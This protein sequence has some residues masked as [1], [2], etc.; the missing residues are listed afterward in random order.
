M[1]SGFMCG[2]DLPMLDNQ[3]IALVIA[4]IIEQESVA[5]IAG[6][7]IK[8]A[9]QPTQQ[10]A[11]SEP[12]AYI[13]KISD[14]RIG[15]PYRDDV[16]INNELIHT[17]LQQYETTFQI[18]VLATQNPSKTNQYTASD[19][20]NLIAYILNSDLTIYKLNLQEIGIL[21]VTDVR[22]PYFLD[23]R[24]RYEANPSLDFTLTHKQIVEKLNPVIQYTEFGIYPI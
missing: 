1:E 6:T 14:K 9:F 7:P 11:N 3:L 24:Q 13:Y 10:G 4:T 19:I 12:T 8:Q 20:A 5:N 23:D 2:G 21:R 17:E 22:N 16:W 18:S 15:S